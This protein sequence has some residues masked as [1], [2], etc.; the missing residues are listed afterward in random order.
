M[1][2]ANNKVCESLWSH[3]YIFFTGVD[4]DQFQSVL[5]PDKVTCIPR[6]CRSGIQRIL[7]RWQSFSWIDISSLHLCFSFGG[8]WLHGWLWAYYSHWFRLQ[9][10]NFVRFNV[11][12][13]FNQHLKAKWFSLHAFLATRQ[14]AQ[15]YTVLSAAVIA[16]LNGQHF[17]LVRA[18]ACHLF[19]KCCDLHMLFSETED[20]TFSL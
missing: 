19:V 18:K 14:N 8:H 9:P 17:M 20:V 1:Q 5:G 10:M 6:P 3:G 15:L 16:F 2:V 7:C 4:V 12:A 13:A 11:G